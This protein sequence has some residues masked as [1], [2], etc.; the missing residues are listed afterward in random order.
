[1][2][3]RPMRADSISLD[4]S[5]LKR[6]SCAQVVVFLDNRPDA[7]QPTGGLRAGQFNGRRTLEGCLVAGGVMCFD[8]QVKPGGHVALDPPGVFFRVLQ[9][10]SDCRPGA[11]WLKTIE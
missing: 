1:M 11:T 10:R 7:A 4:L 3:C 6:M 2:A 9:S 8:T 5:F